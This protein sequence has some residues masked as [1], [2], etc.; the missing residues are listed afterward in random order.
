MTTIDSA[1]R[2]NTPVAAERPARDAA[3]MSRSPGPRRSS[4]VRSQRRSSAV[5]PRSWPCARPRSAAG[6]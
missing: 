4:R 3:A 5:S 6:V 1:E 2:G